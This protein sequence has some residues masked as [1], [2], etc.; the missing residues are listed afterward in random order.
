MLVPIEI[1]RAEEW[2]QAQGVAEI[3][4]EAEPLAGGML[5][6]GGPGSW[7]NEACNLAMDGPISDAELDRVLAFYHERGVRPEVEVAPYADRSLVEGLARR[8]FVLDEFETVMATWV[9]SSETVADRLPWDTAHGIEMRRVLPT[10]DDDADWR[11][12]ELV[13]EAFDD[14]DTPESRQ[15]GLNTMR[16]PRT[17]NFG[18]FEGERLVASSGMEV[19]TDGP[20]GPIACLFGMAT[21]ESYR[22]RGIQQALIVARLAHAASLGCRLVCIHTEPGIPTERNARRLGFE[23]A[24]TKVCL[25][26]P[27]PA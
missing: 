21:R 27:E 16:H 17:A 23:I 15:V 22:R 26:G 7:A 4:L 3:A 8:G 5:C 6:F 24:Y 12:L 13:R 9:D 25:V 19:V 20:H 14:P 18:A 10:G 1:A 11:F 2:R